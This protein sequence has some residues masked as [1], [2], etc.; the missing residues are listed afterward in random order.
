MHRLMM[1]AAR[2]RCAL[3]LFSTS[4]AV[5]ACGG[6]GE[7][8]GTPIPPGGVPGGPPGGPIIS[9]P[10]P[11]ATPFPEDV[12]PA[13]KRVGPCASACAGDEYPTLS[14]AV[15]DLRPGD[16]LDLYPRADGAP[17]AAVKFEAVGK[18]DAPIVV[19]GV[20]V[21][22]KRPTILGGS[23]SSTG[24]AAVY[25]EGSH[26]MLLQNVVVTNGVRRRSGDTIDGHGTNGRFKSC[27]KNEAHEVTLRD[28]VVMDCPNN[29]VLGTDRYSGS[30]TL[31]R[32][33]ITGAGCDPTANVVPKMVCDDVAHPVYV[34][35][36][37]KA[38]PDSRLRVINSVIQDNNA[39]VAIKSRARRLEVYNSWVRVA[40]SHEV[41][42]VD[43]YGFDGQGD[44]PQ[45]ASVQKPVHA[46]LVGNVFLV[47]A[48]TTLAN[49]VIR[50]GSDFDPDENNAN[51]YG[52]VRLL[53]NTL[54]V[55]GNLGQA[56]ASSS[57]PLVRMYGKLEG[58]MAINNVAVV[59]DN[60]K[61]KVLLASEDDD[62]P[63]IWVAAD[64]KPRMYFSHNQLPADSFA[65]RSGRPSVSYA[66]TAA[67]PEGFFW[68]KWVSAERVLGTLTPKLPDVTRDN[69]VPG[70][71]SK[72]A[73]A[74]TTETNPQKHPIDG[75]RAF[76]IPDALE[77]PARDPV[78]MR[79]DGTLAVGSARS[80]AKA[81]T[82][83]AL[84]AA[85]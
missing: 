22:G 40:N 70:K 16:V 79:Q 21:D 14:A 25:F 45:Q 29:G 47:D 63:V 54:V 7:S 19:R 31:E 76:A 17:Y 55:A 28:V 73:Q 74:G 8:G 43:I 42:A 58:L 3:L 4:L 62:H 27:I 56:T 77:F 39:G 69:L 34:A 46:D 9:N 35:T 10:P 1:D 26:H 65:W 51:T 2:R 59:A 83:G 72:L 11:P 44:A 80:D 15:A 20:T 48:S 49:G 32:V 78:A 36:D 24:Y 66:T 18:P 52:R 23:E 71:S 33:V 81:P 30:L 6:G 85:Q 84:Q 68:S 50:T 61:G 60:P 67:S 12:G 37:P 41:R 64:G 75:T 38:H 53:N 57:L 13:N 82:V 5:G